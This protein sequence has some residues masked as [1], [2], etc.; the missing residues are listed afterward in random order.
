MHCA[1]NPEKLA[2][3]LEELLRFDA[4]VPHS[5]FRYAVEP[6]AIGD[7]TIPAGAQ[8]II[9]LAAANRDRGRFEKADDLLLDRAESRHLSFGHGIHHCLGAPLARMEGQIAL[10]SL[11]R[12]FPAL[13]LAVPID[14]LR[15]G[16]GDGLVL[17]GLSELPVITGTAVP[18]T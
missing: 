8:V 7:V 2:F 17:R 1:S 16:H 15:W 10:G 11:L 9:C 14:E 4:P 5:T 12:R 18:R 13:R 3:A 6:M